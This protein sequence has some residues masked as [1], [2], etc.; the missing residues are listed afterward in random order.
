MPVYEF[1]VIYLFLFFS[2][3]L[4][5]WRYQW[6]VR[7]WVCGERKIDHCLSLD[8]C[9]INVFFLGI[10]SL[11]LCIIFFHF[12]FYFRLYC[13]D[14][15]HVSVRVCFGCRAHKYS[16]IWQVVYGL[17]A[18]GTFSLFRLHYIL[19]QNIIFL[20]LL[21]KMACYSIAFYSFIFFLY[22]F[23][24]FSRCFCSFLVHCSRLKVQMCLYAHSYFVFI[25]R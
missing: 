5:D 3:F 14:C 16:T 17:S 25:V 19:N 6:N 4:N 7:S 9:G 8:I 2:T 23:L 10:V 15:V 21:A 1:T 18:F 13:C 11:I 20:L 22:V 24:V 12:A